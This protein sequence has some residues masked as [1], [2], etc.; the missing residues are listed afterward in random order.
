VYEI[1]LGEDA[2][3][4]LRRMPVHVQRRIVAT[5]RAELKHRPTSGQPPRKLLAPDADSGI[6]TSAPVW[7]L[8]VGDYRVFYDV[9]EVRRV[10]TAQRIARKGRKT[11]REVPE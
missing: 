5:M 6:V 11:T 10:V 2:Q 3:G 1:R 7:Q 4:D 8:R 9:D